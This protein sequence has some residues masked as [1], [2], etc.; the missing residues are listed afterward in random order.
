MIFFTNLMVLLASSNMGV[1]KYG[2]P[3]QILYGMEPTLEETPW[4]LL[5]KFLPLIIIVSVCS[6]LIGLFLV[7]KKRKNVKGNSKKR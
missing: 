5:I 7:L 1:A 4:F 3:P 2:P 6:F